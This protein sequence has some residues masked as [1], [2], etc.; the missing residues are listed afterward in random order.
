MHAGSPPQLYC[1]YLEFSGKA[2]SCCTRDQ[3]VEDVEVAFALQTPRETNA[4]V[5]EKAKFLLVECVVTRAQQE[6]MVFVRVCVRAQQFAHAS[7]SPST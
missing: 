5:V 3:L 7:E 6:Y 1:H 4:V 2:S